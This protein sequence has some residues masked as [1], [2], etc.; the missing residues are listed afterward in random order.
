MTTWR[1]TSKIGLFVSAMILGLA[2]YFLVSANSSRVQLP[3]LRQGTPV[4]VDRSIET[5][6]TATVIESCFEI[7][8]SSEEVLKELKAEL[9]GAIERRG[10][11]GYQLVL[12]RTDNGRVRVA[13]YPEISILVRD[14]RISRKSAGAE[15]G[16]SHM[17]LREHRGPSVISGVWRWLSQRLKA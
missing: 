11:E 13:E 1:L 10:A 17:V 15:P 5:G 16:W 12:P 4:Y 7:P 2:G 3:I 14:G 9:P 8:M 6:G